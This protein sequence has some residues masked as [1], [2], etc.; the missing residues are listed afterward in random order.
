ML[1]LV[2]LAFMIMAVWVMYWYWQN[3]EA[4]DILDKTN[5]LFAMIDELKETDESAG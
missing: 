1:A 5:G 2:W 4:T 3:H